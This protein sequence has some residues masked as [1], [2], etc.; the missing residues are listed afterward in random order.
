[1]T[2]GSYLVGFKSFGKIVSVNFNPKW[3]TNDKYKTYVGLEIADFCS[4]FIYNQC[5]YNHKVKSNEFKTIEKKFDKYPS[6]LGKG[7][8]Y[9][10]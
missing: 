4:A 8:K 10:P 2:Y 5:R 1:M 9:I 3:V 6:Y 7:L